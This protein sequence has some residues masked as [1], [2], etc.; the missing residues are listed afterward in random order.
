MLSNDN[1]DQALGAKMLTTI[2]I[3]GK[4]AISCFC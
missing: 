1:F 4:S 3:F 2:D